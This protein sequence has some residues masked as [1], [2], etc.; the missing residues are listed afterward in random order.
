MSEQVKLDHKSLLV[1]L[2]SQHLNISIS[3]VMAIITATGKDGVKTFIKMIEDLWE[4]ND[5]EDQKMLDLVSV[6]M[7]DFIKLH[8]RKLIRE[9]YSSDGFE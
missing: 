9:I 5:K 7:K 3:I 2:L 6:T 4:A 8:E 1:D